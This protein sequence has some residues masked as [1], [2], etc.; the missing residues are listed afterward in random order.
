MTSSRR[1]C[2]V[3]ALL[4]ACRGAANAPA[5]PTDAQP[6][7]E[8][9]AAP[10]GSQERALASRGPSRARAS[11]LRACE[12]RSD[13]EACWCEKLCAE[14][15]SA[16]AADV[17]LAWPLGASG[18]SEDGPVPLG[19]VFEV[20][21]AAG[22]AV[23]DCGAAP[24]IRRCPG[25]SSADP[26]LVGYWQ[27]VPSERPLDIAADA[28]RHRALW[29][30]PDGS[31]V[32]S[33]PGWLLAFG[34]WQRRP[35]GLL[36]HDHVVLRGAGGG[37]YADE[38]GDHVLGVLCQRV[39]RP[40]SPLRMLPLAPCDATGATDPAACLQIDG[41]DHRRLATAPAFDE[42]WYR[43]TCEAPSAP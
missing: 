34:D 17:V 20:H 19:D 33:E 43:R 37:T 31:F 28:Q 16:A 18:M 2:L 21:V 8:P 26:A 6:A 5:T 36:L 27:D 42:A 25:A 23:V 3:L 24:A 11:A 39:A 30:R 13:R 32:R 1:P 29:L 10:S 4:S 9:A 22:G 35:E 12:G 15:F 7:T 40:P 14:P 41:R 38:T